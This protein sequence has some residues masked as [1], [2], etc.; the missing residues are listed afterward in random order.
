VRIRTDDVYRS[1]GGAL[2]YRMTAETPRVRAD[3]AFVFYAR[4]A[5]FMYRYDRAEVGLT[6][7]KSIRFQRCS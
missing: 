5:I 7:F 3:I 4:N 1:T 2:T 6:L